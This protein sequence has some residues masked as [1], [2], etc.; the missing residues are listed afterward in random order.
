[1][2]RKGSG[3]TGTRSGGDSS[4]AAAERLANYATEAGAQQSGQSAPA[5]GS[6][7]LGSP[8]IEGATSLGTHTTDVGDLSAGFEAM[9]TGP[10][11]NPKDTGFGKEPLKVII[12]QTT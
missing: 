4:S 12:V 9:S 3:K 8:E 11:S 10:I 1:M 6:A 5:A 7:G 2:I